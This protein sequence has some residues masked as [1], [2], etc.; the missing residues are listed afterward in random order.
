MHKKS[1]ILVAL[2]GVSFVTLMLTIPGR[3]A[4]EEKNV[5]RIAVPQATKATRQQPE[6]PAPSTMSTAPL[7]KTASATIEPV[8]VSLLKRGL[9]RLTSRDAAGA[10]AVRN[11][12]PIGALDRQILNWAIGMSGQSAISS[13]QLAEIAG[14][15]GELPGKN[16]IR[17]NFERALVR[18]GADSNKILGV[19][20]AQEPTTTDGKIAYAKALVTIG[21]ADQ[22]QAIIRQL[23]S[24]EMLSPTTEQDLQQLLPALKTVEA[25]RERFFM[26]AFRGRMSEAERFAE[27]AKAKSLFAAWKAIQ[28]R[29]KSAKTAL[30]AVEA[31]WQEHPSYQYLKVRLQRQL[32]NYREAA[33]LLQRVTPESIEASSPNAWWT[34]MRIISRGI[35]DLGDSKRAYEIVAAHPKLDFGEEADAEFH[36]GWLSQRFNKAPK[37]AETHFRQMLAVSETPISTAKAHYW[38]ARSLEA[39]KDERAKEHFEQAAHHSAT[40]YGQI[41]AAK[42]GKKLGPISPPAIQD[43]DRI[44]LAGR[45]IM[46]AIDRLERAGYAWRADILYRTLA[47][48]IDRP[49]ELAILTERLE[50]RGAHQISL[51]VGRT[52]FNRGVEEVALAFPMSAIP[53]DTDIG[54]TGKAL[55]FAIARQESAFDVGAISPA[56]AQGLLQILPGTAKDVASKL[57]LEFTPSRLTT[58]A[59]YNAQLGAQYL[60]EQI[61]RFDG[62]YIL[63]FIAYN[64]GPRRVDEWIKR[65]GDP[66]GQSLEKVVDWIERIPFPETRNYVQRVIENYQVYKARL[67]KEA[68]IAK[69][70]TKGR[71]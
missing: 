4:P 8:D 44:L 30:S 33:K 31:E 57:K 1:V 64:A 50:A 66:R 19:F 23:W 48:E 70:L 6:A 3:E 59:A 21:K 20:N 52:A 7:S 18:E 56:N 2:A 42:L 15:I 69:D 49:G 37:L 11:Q 16:T 63:T 39:Q 55:A 14:D 28:Q 13:D 65:F 10:L 62:S 26:L 5:E 51:Q 9:D 54:D 24:E 47:G 17:G 34:E 12:M 58:D 36:A 61:T 68:N 35:L 22:T 27:P 67:G 25:Q 29:D 71:L 41:A 38:L 53:A 40:F 60:A 32:S 43:E 46:H 45:P